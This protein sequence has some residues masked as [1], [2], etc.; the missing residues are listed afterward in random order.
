MRSVIITMATFG[1]VG[2]LGQLDSPGGVGPGTNPN[3]TGDNSQGRKMFEQNV[4]P[5]IR[6]PGQASD[7][8]QCH[9]SAQPSGNVTGFVSAN[10]ADAYATATSFQAVVGNFTPTSAEIVTQVDNH[11]QNRVYTADQKQK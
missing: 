9:D 11:H 3:P 8:S 2:C 4:Y 7:C 5:I 10:V 1:L 6:N